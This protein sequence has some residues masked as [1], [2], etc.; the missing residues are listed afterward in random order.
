MVSTAFLVIHDRQQAEDIAQ[1]AFTQLLVHWPKIS[2]YDRPESWIRRVAIRAAV[3]YVR[4]ERMRET[5]ERR[6]APEPAIESATRPRRVAGDRYPA[7]TATR[8]HRALLLEDRPTR[9]MAD[10]F[11]CS[12][13]RA[14]VHLFKARKRLA[15]VLGEEALDVP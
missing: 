13:S 6:V 9:E 4:R 12:D 3:R 7:A 1:D 10:I 11:G 5:L 15:A 2:R 14:K 8:R